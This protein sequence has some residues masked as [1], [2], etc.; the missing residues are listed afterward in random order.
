MLDD[1]FIKGL[2]Y[3]IFDWVMQ[4]EKFSRYELGVPSR[5]SYM[6]TIRRKSG[7]DLWEYAQN[8]TYRISCQPSIWKREYL[9]YFLKLPHNPWKFEIMQNKLSVNDSARIIATNPRCL[10][11][12]TS[13]ALSRNW[14]NQININGMEGNDLMRIKRLAHKRGMGTINI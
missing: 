4:N 10:D 14:Q 1:F 3:H 2:N 6:Q 8:S 12:I 9:L 13:S 5:F 11:Y 7:F